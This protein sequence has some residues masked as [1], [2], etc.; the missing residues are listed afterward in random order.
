MNTDFDH[1][2]LAL[3][4]DNNELFMFESTSQMGV[5]LLSWDLFVKSKCHESYSQIGF[6][7]L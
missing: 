3:R 6:R 2:A 7:H 4:M 5:N 1:V